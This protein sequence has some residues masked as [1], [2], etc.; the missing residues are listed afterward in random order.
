[1]PILFILI[2]LKLS[3][4]LFNTLERVLLISIYS[5]EAHRGKKKKR[6]GWRINTLD[7]LH[8]C[9]TLLCTTCCLQCGNL[10]TQ[11][12]PQSVGFFS[13]ACNEP[14]QVPRLF[15]S[16]EFTMLAASAFVHH[17]LWK[18]RHGMLTPAHWPWWWTSFCLLPVVSACSHSASGPSWTSPQQKFNWE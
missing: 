7:F 14:A 8:W 1:M 15:S 17:L 11:C 12:L 13:N 2:C 9:H 16:V 3:F 4:L 5:S 10:E 18:T 6:C